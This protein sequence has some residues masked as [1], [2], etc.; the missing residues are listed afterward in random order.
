MS[1]RVYLESI[2]V[3]R[4]H[5]D[6]ISDQKF[7]TIRLCNSCIVSTPAIWKQHVVDGQHAVIIDSYT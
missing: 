1:K 3:A 2:D 4:H 7:I 6:C 5:R